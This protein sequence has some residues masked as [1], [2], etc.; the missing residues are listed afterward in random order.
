MNIDFTISDYNLVT[1]LLTEKIDY[2]AD[3]LIFTSS[4]DDAIK[5][6]TALVKARRNLRYV[7]YQDT[8]NNE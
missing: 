6:L 5:E 2:T 4:T 8:S 1:K 7:V 3:L